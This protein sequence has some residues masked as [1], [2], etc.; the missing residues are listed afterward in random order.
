MRNT[1]PTAI[2]EDG[3][4]LGEDVVIGPYCVVGSNV[5]LGAGVRLVSHVVVAG[6]T[7]IGA[8]CVIY[9]FASL[10][11]P[12]QHLRYEGEKTRL[13]VGENNTIREYV[14]MNPGTAL[15][16]NQTIVGNNGYFMVGSHIAHDCIVGDEVIFANNATLGG[17]VTIGDYVMIGGLSAVQQHSRI[18]NYAF[19]GG[20]SGVTADVIPYGSVQGVSCLVGLN[21]IGMKRRG[22]S[23]EKIRD[24][25]NAYRLLFNQESTFHERLQDIATKFIKNPEVMEI[26]EFI[27][28]ASSRSIVLP[29]SQDDGN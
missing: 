10:G 5:K 2:I 22:L 9:P 6:D 20:M 3:A 11:Q 14:T 27:Q 29:P 18:G 8:N 26:V 12:P 17:H 4:E 25:R 7:R 28:S 19:I 24:L 13:T 15:G 23:R 21:I 1:H 16:C